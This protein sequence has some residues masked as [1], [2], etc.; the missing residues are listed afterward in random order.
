MYQ[1]TSLLGFN[2]VE[3]VWVGDC[4]H[5]LDFE[6][7][8][9]AEDVHVSFEGPLSIGHGCPK[10]VMD[11]RGQ[12]GMNSGTRKERADHMQNAIFH[13]LAEGRHGATTSVPPGYSKQDGTFPRKG[14]EGRGPNSNQNQV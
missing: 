6:A 12:K 14:G 11:T 5:A 9:L 10:R 3:H 2:L 13:S 4:H 1:Y 7:Q 8:E